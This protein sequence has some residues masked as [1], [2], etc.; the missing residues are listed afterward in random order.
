MALD[1]PSSPS[2]NDEYQLG[3]KTWYWTGSA[4]RLKGE[5]QDVP[6]IYDHANGAFTAAN[7]ASTTATA[8]FAAANTAQTT[9]DGAYAHANGAFDAA[10]TKFASSGGS[11][12]GDVSITG[13]LT[14]TGET[15]YANT[16]TVNL[17]DNIITL[18]ADI[19]QGSAPSVD[20]GI[21]VDRGS[22]ANVQLLWNETDDVWTFTNDGSTYS[23]IA[24]NTSVS[25]AQTTA[26]GAYNHA[27][28]AFTAANSAA[29]SD[30]TNVSVSAGTY[31]N[32]T[33]VASITLAAN[34]RVTA[35]STSDI[36]TL[37]SQ[38]GNNGY[39]LQTDGTTASWAAI[40]TTA[41]TAAF[42]HAN[43]AY[44]QANTDFTNVSI[45]AGDY[46]SA[47]IIPVVHLEANGRVS[48]VTNTTITSSS[49]S[50][51]GIVQLT[52]ATNSTST[53][54]AA[55]P[56]AVKSA[57]DLADTANTNAAAAQ[58]TAD[59]A[60][61]HAE[62]AFTQA[63]TNSTSDYTNVSITAGDY[64]SAVIIPV[65]HL[66]ANGRV[67]AVTNTTITSS[68][69]STAGI[70]QLTDATNSTSTTTAATPNAVKSA[71]DLASTANTNAATA[72]S[73]ADGAQTHAEAAFTQ[74]NTNASSITTTNSRLD[75]AFGHANGAFDAANTKFAS[76]GGTISGDTTITGNLT[77]T[78][79]R[80]Y[81]NTVD[82]LIADNIVTLNAAIDQA[83]APALNAGIE[84]DRGSSAN[85]LLLWNETDDVWTF[86]N[87][88]STYYSVPTNTS[89]S[90]AQTTADGAYGHANG[91]F[92]AA[93]T[94]QTTAD[95]AFTAANTAQST[96]DGAQT[97]AEAAFTKANTN[98]TTDYTAV[99]ITA[100]DYGSATIIPVVHL[101]ANG[102]VSAVTNTSIT[103]A[104]TSDAGIVQ[105]TDATNSTS[106]TTAATP[107]AVK[108]AYDLASTANT[109][110]ATAQTT[111]DGAY[112]HA[113]GAFAKANTV[114]ITS[115]QS[116][117]P[118]SP[119][120][121]DRWIDSDDGVEYIYI[122]DGDTTVWVEFG[123][124]GLG[125]DGIPSQT[126]NSG[127]YLTTD[128][129]T[130]SWGAVIAASD[131][132][133]TSETANGSGTTFTVTS[134]HNANSLIVFYNGIALKPATDYDVS[135]T[136][137]TTTFT[138]TANADIVIRY[139]PIV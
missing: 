7:T 97:H 69:T 137:L 63:N 96:A 87:D 91:A 80:T 104:S 89:V 32:A 5:Q 39:Y 45:V 116:T 38:T 113:N 98:S 20:A 92:T 106:T 40:D 57:Y 108:S 110:A 85:V 94:A 119:S 1:F 22:S 26:D 11:I 65:L 81:A 86:T 12:S 54:T 70:V 52:D 14:I 25:T 44:D 77:V 73:T 62:G 51:A 125:I 61:T 41:I 122:N 49:T 55:T 67:S 66:E 10:N 84:V 4:W 23:A 107:N 128:G 117:A 95:G 42:A 112:G 74:A 8:A 118:S 83:S 93:N 120:V 139:L 88:G 19:P 100:G 18:N 132:S 27:N 64:G 124:I 75:S 6:G 36:D 105:L 29:T 53:T 21:E 111:A 76:A 35:I 33:A 47:T 43:A 136:T 48:A 101:E 71:Y 134:G 34:G 50:T 131:Y 135:G 28:G 130:A 37:P 2:T 78:G 82:T 16:T 17:G 90:T 138:P 126:G 46:G 13:N 31:G 127:K 109:N 3:N 102:R 79:T 68:S 24:S 129:T 72:Q 59:G 133:S 56:N 99:S 121:G 123:G 60:Q 115:F 103:S 30:Y 9:A 114:P 58:S 15:T